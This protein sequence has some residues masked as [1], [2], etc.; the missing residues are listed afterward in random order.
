MIWFAYRAPAP[1]EVK[2]NRLI[3]GLIMI[4]AVFFQQIELFY[5]YFIINLI[6]VITTLRLSPTSWLL[7]LVL[8]LIKRPLYTI[9]PVYE[10]SYFMNHESELF[11]LS[12]RLLVSFIAIVF[13]TY[14]PLVTWLV[15]AI[16]GIFMMIST[17]FGFCLSSLAYIGVMHL[18]KTSASSSGLVENK[19]ALSTNITDNFV[20]LIFYPPIPA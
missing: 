8:F 10:R 18:Q 13:F 3:L 14:C 6:T 15:G 17:F 2:F 19:S 20:K 11:E 16:M 5:L 7:S 4:T 1:T 9:S 12:L